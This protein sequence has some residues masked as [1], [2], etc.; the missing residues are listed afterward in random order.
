MVDSAIAL[1]TIRP[2][3][4]VL[5]MPGNLGSAPAAAI[6]F[7]AAVPDHFRNPVA[8]HGSMAWDAS[9]S[10]CPP[11]RSPARTL[12]GR[13]LRTAQPRRRDPRRRRRLAGRP[14]GGED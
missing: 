3:F 12:D 11:W 7:L 8:F 1:P 13:T 6:P 2:D 14:R 5:P 9:L 4:D 10:A